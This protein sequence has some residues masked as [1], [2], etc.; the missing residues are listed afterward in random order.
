MSH[1]LYDGLDRF[2]SRRHG[3][4]I[5]PE[6]RLFPSYPA[7]LLMFRALVILGSALG[8]KWHYMV[9]A[10]RYAL[11][12]GGMLI[13]TISVNAYLLQW[14][15]EAPGEVGLWINMGRSF[16]RFMATFVQIEWVERFSP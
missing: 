9:V 8:R 14:Y 13:M 16:G 10:V 4:T 6:L 1:W 12:I 11:Q 15:P 7:A 2:L 5:I 3:D